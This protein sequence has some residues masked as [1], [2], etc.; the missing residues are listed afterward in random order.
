MA[1]IKHKDGVID[2]QQLEATLTWVLGKNCQFTILP[3]YKI[4]AEGE[5]VMIGDRVI[6]KSIKGG[7]LNNVPMTMYNEIDNYH[8]HESCFSNARAGEHL[9]SNSMESKTLQALSKAF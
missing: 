1:I 6:I 7:F 9:N 4:R 2:H 8:Y 5:P 3:R